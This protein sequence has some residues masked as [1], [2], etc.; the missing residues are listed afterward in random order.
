MFLTKKDCITLVNLSKMCLNSKF[1][2]FA[3]KEKCGLFLLFF[4]SIHVF[5]VRLNDN[6]IIF[7]LFVLPETFLGSY[8]CKPLTTWVIINT[9]SSGRW[10]GAASAGHGIDEAAFC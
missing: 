9:V 3:N 4:F 2:F 1:F 8:P 5:T 6:D 7:G 10:N